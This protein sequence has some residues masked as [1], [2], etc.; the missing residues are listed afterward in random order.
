MKRISMNAT[1]VGQAMRVDGDN[2]QAALM[3]VTDPR[4]R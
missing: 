1:P 2:I 3:R 4:C